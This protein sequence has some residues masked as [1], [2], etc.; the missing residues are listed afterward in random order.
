MYL[1]SSSWTLT[2]VKN[3]ARE[4][5]KTTLITMKRKKPQHPR[6]QLELDDSLGSTL[7]VNFEKNNQCFNSKQTSLT[8]CPETFVRRFL[9]F[10]VHDDCSPVVKK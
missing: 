2:A 9:S 6:L 7:P 10:L 5:S 3:I 4:P 1:Y 8:T